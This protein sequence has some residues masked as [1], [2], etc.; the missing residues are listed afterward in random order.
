MEIQSPIVFDRESRGCAISQ[1]SLG[2]MFDLSHSE[3]RAVKTT[4]TTSST[5]RA[6]ATAR[7]G[8]PMSWIVV[9]TVFKH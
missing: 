7:M 8:M 6:V 9:A 5:F 1:F 3:V 4:I 2:W